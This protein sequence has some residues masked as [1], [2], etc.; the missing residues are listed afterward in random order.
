MA[1]VLYDS[2]SGFWR[3]GGLNV[4][5]DGGRDDE[6]ELVADDVVEVDMDDECRRPIFRGMGRG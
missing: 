5:G 3:F 2:A 6:G 4:N 1:C